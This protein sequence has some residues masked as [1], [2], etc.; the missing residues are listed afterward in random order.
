MAGGK[1]GENPNRVVSGRMWNVFLNENEAKNERY[2]SSERA[3]GKQEFKVRLLMGSI[4]FSGKFTSENVYLSRRAEERKG[5]VGEEKKLVKCVSVFIDLF[6]MNLI[7]KKGFCSFLASFFSHRCEQ[8]ENESFLACS[9]HALLKFR[10]QIPFLPELELPTIP[11]YLIH[12]AFFGFFLNSYYI[13][14]LYP[15]AFPPLIFLHPTR[16]LSAPFFCCYSSDETRE[17]L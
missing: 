5:K 15:L 17:K 9:V 13:Y 1:K 6:F 2:Q 14:F 3:K 12:L 16:V 10:S 4:Q 8:D 7:Q 11:L